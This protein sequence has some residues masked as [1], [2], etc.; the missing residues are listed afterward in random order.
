[1]QDSVWPHAEVVEGD[2]AIP[3]RSSHSKNLP[4]RV[5]VAGGAEADLHDQRLQGMSYM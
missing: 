4:L 2:N 3:Q 1:M 5:S